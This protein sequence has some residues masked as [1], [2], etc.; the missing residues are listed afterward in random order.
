[1]SSFKDTVLK[2]LYYEYLGKRQQTYAELNVLLDNPV[3]VGDHAV[4]AKDVG[5]KI[6]AL[7]EINSF[8]DT[9]V[10]EFE[11]IVSDQEP[12]LPDGSPEECKAGGTPGPEDISHS[13]QTPLGDDDCCDDGKCEC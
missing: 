5:D 1:M 9:I 13:D 4:Q 3:G 6:R 10:E 12:F 11:D 8:I 2:G 7:E